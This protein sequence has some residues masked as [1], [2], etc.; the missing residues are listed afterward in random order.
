MDEPDTGGFYK[1]DSENLFFGP[2]YVLNKDYELLRET[3]EQHTYPVDGWS[4]FENEEEARV[5]FGL[6]QQ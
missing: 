4:W 2:N 5:N 6:L 3:H 1:T